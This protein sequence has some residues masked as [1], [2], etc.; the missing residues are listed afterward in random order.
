MSLLIGEGCMIDSDHSHGY[1]SYLV[2]FFTVKIY[3]QSIN[4]M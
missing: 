3:S 1:L 2:S 4:P